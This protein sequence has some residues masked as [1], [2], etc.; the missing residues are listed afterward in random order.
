MAHKEIFEHKLKRQAEYCVRLHSDLIDQ[1]KSWCKKHLSSHEWGL[2]KWTCVYE[3][4]FIFERKE[5][6]DAF[7][8]T[9]A[10]YADQEPLDYGPFK[11]LRIN[12]ES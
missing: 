10:E 4:T 7:K 8:E 1:G 9:F 12:N 5:D 11:K 2:N 3:H 6:A